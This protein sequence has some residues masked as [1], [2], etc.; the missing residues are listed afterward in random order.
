MPLPK[1]LARFNRRVTNRVLG[2]A[3]PYVPPMAM[4]VHRGR[5]SGR[6]YS[7]PVLAFPTDGGCAIALT[8][9]P[10]T[11]WVRNVLAAQGCLLRR[12][13]GELELTNP[14]ISDGLHLLPAAFRPALRLMNVTQV[15]HLRR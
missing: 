1:R 15:L 4:V 11:D 3:A 9:G 2:T 13:G 7:T 6:R 8:Y 5:R 10:D 12:R 14:V